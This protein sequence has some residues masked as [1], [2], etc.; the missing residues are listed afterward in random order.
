MV[1]LFFGVPVTLLDLSSFRFVLFSFGSFCV[2]IDAVAPPKFYADFL[3]LETM[4]IL[5]GDL[6]VVDVGQGVVVGSSSVIPTMSPS[7]FSSL[8]ISL[9]S[10]GLFKIDGGIVVEQ[11]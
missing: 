10:N 1:G 4:G 9:H 11:S 8:L 2:A 7:S 6:F 3:L 5:A